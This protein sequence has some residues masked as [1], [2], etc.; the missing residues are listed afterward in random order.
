MNMKKIIKNIN[1]IASRL[2]H[3]FKNSH[4]FGT[5]KLPLEKFGFKKN[6]KEKLSNKGIDRI[7]A[8]ALYLKTN[9]PPKKNND[10]WDLIE[11]EINHKKFI[12][13]VSG[14]RKDKSEF[15]K[16]I[17][18]L[19]KTNLLSGFGPNRASYIDLT[20][21]RSKENDE[22]IHFLD[23][24]ISLS[25]YYGIIKVFNPEQGGWIVEIE[26]YDDLIKKIFRKKNISIFETPNYYYGYKFNK[27]FLFSKDLKGLYA[28]EQLRN[29]IKNNDI[30]EVIEIGAGIGYTCH[31]LK[32]MLNIKYTIYDLPYPS[33]LQAIYLMISAGENNVHLDNEKYT[34]KKNFF[35]KPYWKIFEQKAKKNILWFNEDSIPEIDFNLTKKYIKKI[36][37]SKKSFFLS[38]N[39]EARNVYGRGAKQHTVSDLL[40]KNNRIY[41][42]RDFLRPGYIEE[43]YEII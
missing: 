8:Y 10:L 36:L 30:S 19:G 32:Q 3:D 35:L 38:I 11:K 12:N 9:N 41:R 28:A 37:Q 23:Y 42:S 29:I 26:N 16:T 27:E 14:I 6:L 1:R 7:S 33:L 18:D 21:K 24:L 15:I 22:K 31:Y 17:N 43:L 13:M 40:K 34:N 4:L 20:N 39:Q 5:K 25:E 2:N